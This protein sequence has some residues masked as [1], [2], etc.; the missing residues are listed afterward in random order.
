ME[1]IKVD[2]ERLGRV[3]NSAIEIAPFMVF[4]GE[5][6]MGKSYLALLAHYFYDV[7]IIPERNPRLPFLFRHLNYDYREMAKSFQGEGVALSITKKD[8]ESWMSDDAI[9][10]LRFMLNSD[11]LDGK[12]SVKLPNSVPENIVFNYRE[13]YTGLVNNEDVDIILQIEGI[14][15]RVS[16]SAIND[17]TPYAAVLAAY[18]QNCLFNRF[19]FIHST[20]NM[21]PSRG[22][23]LSE[24]VIPNSGMYRDFISDIN[25]LSNVSPAPNPQADALLGQIRSIMEG[26]VKKEDSRYVYL[27]NDISIPISAAASSIREIAPLQILASRWDISKTAILI[28]EPEAHLHPGKQ[29]MMADVIGC[30]RKAGAQVHLTTH[31]D[32]F[33][34]RLNELILFQRYSNTHRQEEVNILRDKTGINPECGIE[35]KDILTYLVLR[36][37]DGSSSVVLQDLK[38]GIPYT[39][40]RDAIK[41]G[42]RVND[43][44]EE[45]LCK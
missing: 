1:R 24:I 3:V 2:I 14:G 43:L 41:E 20:F 44:L 16:H 8:I 29:R 17:V 34:Q 32:Y 19:D 4:S 45:A 36:Q 30:I 27:T 38:Q 21:P 23:V 42:M 9:S 12:I 11:S 39:S 26:E 18:L 6:G 13:E 37:E 25:D 31:S 22:P 33:L 10:Y 35:E 28:E 15:Y 40:F 7:L 5:S